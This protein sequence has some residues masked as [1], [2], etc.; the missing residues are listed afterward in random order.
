MAISVKGFVLSTIFI[1]MFCLGFF[2]LIDEGISFYNVE[3]Q[4]PFNDT[5]NRLQSTFDNFE[6]LGNEVN[7]NVSSS[8]VTSTELGLVKVG[9][10]FKAAK[11]ILSVPNI[12]ITL[13]SD[14]SENLGL[15]S[16]LIPGI[17]I[18]LTIFVAFALI[19]IVFKV[20]L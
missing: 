5:S 12:L 8:E 1:L 9:P 15:P 4:H 14:L 17:L 11:T 2:A 7:S 20:E 3:V 13:L 10:V 19:K 16:W 6:S 18:M